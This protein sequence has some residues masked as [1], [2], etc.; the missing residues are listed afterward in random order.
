MRQRA[1][2]E[3][4]VNLFDHRMAAVHLV[5][6]DSIECLCADGGEYP[7][8]PVGLKQRLLA[9]GQFG[10]VLLR[11]PTDDQSS[12]NLLGAFF[13]AKAVKGTSAT[14]ASEIQAPESS[15]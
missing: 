14:S 12:L 13:E 7:V 11:N 1:V 6:G 15:S 8:V 3:F 4:G 2:F 9:G 5:S 10:L